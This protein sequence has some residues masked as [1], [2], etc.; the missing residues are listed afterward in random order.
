MKFLIS[1]SGLR[2]F[3][4][5][6][7]KFKTK[8]SFRKENGQNKPM[9]NQQFLLINNLLNPVKWQMTIV[10]CYRKYFRHA[11]SKPVV[12]SSGWKFSGKKVEKNS[13]HFQFSAE[14]AQVAESFALKVYLY[15][16]FTWNGFYDSNFCLPS[17]LLCRYSAL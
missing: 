12:W 2:Q 14:L 17:L 4:L 15:R 13:F 16:N 6:R 8:N 7:K 1:S 5:E 9:V 11:L 10:F 3:G